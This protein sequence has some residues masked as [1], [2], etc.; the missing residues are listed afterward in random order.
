MEMSNLSSISLA[1]CTCGDSPV[2]VSVFMN[3]DVRDLTFHDTYFHVA[4]T[5]FHDQ[6]W[7]THNETYSWHISFCHCPAFVQITFR[8][9]MF[10]L[11]F[12]QADCF[13]VLWNVTFLLSHNV[14]YACEVILHLYYWYFVS[15]WNQMSFLQ[16]NWIWT[17]I[18]VNP[19]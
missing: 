1:L 7:Y 12:S 13:G 17:R 6:F 4:V 2:T 11:S 15:S 10:W 8:S 3:S 9:V 18:T 19:N 16:W 14:L 5:T